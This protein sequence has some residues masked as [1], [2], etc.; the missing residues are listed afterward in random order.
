MAAATAVLTAHGL[1]LHV[2]A[3][4][5]GVS[6]SVRAF[7][8]SCRD[9]PHLGLAPTE[10]DMACRLGYLPLVLKLKDRPC[11]TKAMDWAAANGHLHVVQYLHGHRSEGCTVDAIDRAAQNGHL[12]VVRF[13]TTQRHEGYTANAMVWAAVHGHVDV[14]MALHDTNSSCEWNHDYALNRAIANGHEHVGNWVQSVFVH[15]RPSQN[16]EML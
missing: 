16:P 11:T 13:L 2:L 8:A 10:L 1:V 9:L 7:L 14:L 15:P 5:P 12:D 3:Y 4:A 6:F